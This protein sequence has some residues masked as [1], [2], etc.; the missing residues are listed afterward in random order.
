MGGIERADDHAREVPSL[1]AQLPRE[2][3]RPAVGRPP[4]HRLAHI[5]QVLRAIEVGAE[6]LPVAQVD[7]LGLEVGARRPHDALGIDD[8]HLDDDLAAD[9]GMRDDVP[10]VL[11]AEALLDVPAQV[12]KRLVDLAERTEDILLEETRVIRQHARLL[13]DLALAGGEVIVDD[14]RPQGGDACQ[15]DEVGLL[16]PELLQAIPG[17]ALL[18]HVKALA[19]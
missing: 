12:E 15:T 18:E 1:V 4:D 14:A 13:L 5:E 19:R 9:V 7:G 2:L 3:H 8:R 16:Q 6:M 17:T 10:E 11:L